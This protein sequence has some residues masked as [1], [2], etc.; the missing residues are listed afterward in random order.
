MKLLK[1]TYLILQVFLVFFIYSND[2]AGAENSGGFWKG[3]ESS[4]KEPFIKIV[5]TPDEWSGLWKRAFDEPAPEIDFNQYVVACVFLGHQADWLYSISIGDA[6]RRGDV[7]VVSYGM[8][9]MVLELSRPF[10][11]RGQ[12]VMRVLEK[13]KGAPMILEEDT[14]A[15]RRR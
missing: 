1:F 9:E 15:R 8:A 14:A 11:A 13:K 7:W 5:A 2:S 10:K 12:Y 4:Q 6:A 3:F